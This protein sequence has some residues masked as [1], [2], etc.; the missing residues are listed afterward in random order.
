MSLTSD[1]RTHSDHECGIGA[2]KSRGSLYFCH[3]AQTSGQKQQR[4]EGPYVMITGS[5][6]R[7]EGAAATPHE[8]QSA[9]TAH[10]R[11]WRP[12]GRKRPQCGPG[13]GERRGGATP[14]CD[15]MQHPDRNSRGTGLGLLVRAAGP[16]DIPCCGGRT[17]STFS[18][19][20]E[21]TNHGL[22]HSIRPKSH[23]RPFLNTVVQQQKSSTRKNW[24]IRP[25][26]EIK[27]EAHGTRPPP[28]SPHRENV[29]VCPRDRYG[30]GCSPLAL[31]FN[32]V[33]R[34]P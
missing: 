13:G 7:A 16:T 22:I 29:E 15:R 10:G 11:G 12:E 33:L 14:P 31:L 20:E 4:D 9:L 28:S 26:V 8:H 32:S 19:T 6:D 21:P 1:V 17:H 24:Q 23:Q 27:R 34:V 30:R 5:A 18:G 25:Y 2:L 3:T